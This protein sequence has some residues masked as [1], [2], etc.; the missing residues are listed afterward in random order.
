MRILSSCASP[1]TPRWERK[2]KG[3]FLSK[4]INKNPPASFSQSMPVTVRTLTKE[5]VN[6]SV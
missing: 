2:Q 1:A 6:V 3:F 4:E 5:G